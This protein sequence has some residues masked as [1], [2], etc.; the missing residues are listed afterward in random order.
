M[1][2]GKSNG[3]PIFTVVGASYETLGTSERSEATA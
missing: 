3:M 2:S 1:P